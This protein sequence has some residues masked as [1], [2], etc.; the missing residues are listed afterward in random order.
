[1]TTNAYCFIQQKIDEGSFDTVRSDHAV[2]GYIDVFQTMKKF[3]EER[4]ARLQTYHGDVVAAMDVIRSI[5]ECFRMLD[6][7][8][9]EMVKPMMEPILGSPKEEENHENS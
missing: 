6:K 3:F 8:E 2:D 4:I 1:M 5:D 7:I 9:Y